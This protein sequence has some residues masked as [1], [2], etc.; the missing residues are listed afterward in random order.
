MSIATTLRFSPEVRDKLK[1]IQQRTGQPTTQKTVDYVIMQHE[2]QGILIAALKGEVKELTE[3]LLR[4]QNAILF[5][6]NAHKDLI[7]LK[8]D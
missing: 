1:E 8:V 6:Q 5:F 2:V 7:N 4:Y 3:T